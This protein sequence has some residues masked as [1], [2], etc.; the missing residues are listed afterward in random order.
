[1][2]FRLIS[3]L[4]SP[5]KLRS[6]ASVAS[7]STL[8]LCFRALTVVAL[9]AMVFSPD[10]SS[11]ETIYLKSG[12]SISVT[13]TQE[14][15]GQILYWVGGDQYSISKDSVA[16]IEAGDAPVSRSG[17][18]GSGSGVQDLTRRESPSATIHDKVNLQA[19][20]GPKQND[21]YWTGLRR[22]IMTAD[23][24]D[25]QRLAEI[26]IQH[27]NRTTADAFYL[28]AVTAMQD[29]DPAKASGYF[30]HAIRAMPDRVDLLEWHALT[31][32]AQG[33]YPDAAVELERA[34]TL[35][36][37]S[38]ELLRM[39]GSA[40]YNADRVGDAIAAWKRAQQLAPDPAIATRLQKA[41]REL[42]VEENSRRKESR[43]F[44]LHYQGDRTSPEL[45]EQILATLESAYQDISRQLSFEPAENIIVI[46]YTKTEFM[47]ITE[48]PTWASALNDGKLRI[49]IGGISA[50]DGEVERNLRHELTHSFVHWLSKG[51]CPTW[52]NE[53]LAQLMEPR[54]AGMYAR[55]L[56]P[57]F[58]ERKAIPFAALHYSF[59]RFS[60]A[61]AEIAYAESLS[62]TEYLRDRYGMFEI[63]RM[64]QSIGSGVEPETALTN[65]TGMDYDA[66]AQRIGEQMAKR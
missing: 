46:L 59:T 16:R 56:G 26:E 31:L 41:E 20:A 40:R 21:A 65:S 61:Q 14:K 17:Y 24:I 8:R 33:R 54:S 28:A 27:N 25:D 18:A 50:V 11:A 2:R 7:F 15:D 49:P 66:L 29:R 38:P 58:L 6:V 23:I 43:H 60:A 36:P 19:P 22:R 45:Q 39:L 37:D 47:D 52:L 48:A 63:T 3:V 13:R 64:L 1:M 35:Q 9:V 4:I 44:T 10:H 5:P 30:E 62:A 34:N 55:E 42:Q 51:H 57:L 32:A 53:G 12:I